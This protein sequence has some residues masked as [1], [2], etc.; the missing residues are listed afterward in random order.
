MVVPERESER[1]GFLGLLHDDKRLVVVYAQRSSTWSNV[2][3]RS[4][5]LAS[6]GRRS[7][8]PRDRERRER[9]RR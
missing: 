2:E 8:M 9:K 7:A 4:R 6:A 1:N 3:T 5:F